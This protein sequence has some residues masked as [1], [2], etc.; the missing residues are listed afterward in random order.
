M[1]GAKVLVVEDEEKILD[2]VTSYLE[3]NGYTVR[4]ASTG[5]QALDSFKEEEPDCIILD[6]MLPDLSGEIVCQTIRRKSRV[7]IIMLTAKAGE[8][9]LLEGFTIGADDYLTKPFSPREL[10]ARVSALLRRTSRNEGPLSL[11]YEFDDG[12]KIDTVSKTVKRNGTIIKLTH[13]EYMLL[14]VFVSHPGRTFTREELINLS[15]GSEYPGYDRTIDAHI[16]NLRRKI[17][18]NCKEPVYIVTAHGI[19]YRFR[20]VDD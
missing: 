14:I 7:P 17:E 13:H 18:V 10:I 11:S 5:R 6:L 3:K 20:G 19:G 9:D 8:R 15:F 2:V 16:K 1:N 4:Q 12:L